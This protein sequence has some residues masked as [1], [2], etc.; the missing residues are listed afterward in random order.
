MLG[1]QENEPRIPKMT[2]S[3]LRRPKARR[4]TLTKG[5]TCNLTETKATPDRGTD[6]M[7]A[8][9]EQEIDLRTL[10]KDEAPLE[11]GEVTLGQDEPTSNTVDP[12]TAWKL[13]MAQFFQQMRCDQK[14]STGETKKG[15]DLIIT[16]E[17]ESRIPKMTL[18][19]LRRPKARRL[20]LTKGKTCNL[21]E[22]KAT[23]DRGTDTMSAAPEQEI[24][25]RTLDKDE[26]PSKRM[27]ENEWTGNY[28]EYC[29][30]FSDIVSNGE[31]LPG[32]DLIMYF[33]AGLPTD[34]GDELT[35]KGKRTFSTWNEAANALRAYMVPFN[36]WRA[37][38]K[39]ALQELQGAEK[40][41]PKRRSHLR[42]YG[43]ANRRHNEAVYGVNR[44]TYST[45]RTTMDGERDTTR[46]FE[47]TGQGHLGRECPLRN[48]VAR[49]RGETCSKCGGMDHYAR[50]CATNRRTTNGNPRVITAMHTE[51]RE[52]ES[53]LNEKA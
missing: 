37:Q 19:E 13:E 24:D 53:R 2:L 30:E 22:T 36:L 28:N 38:R 31:E 7:S 40:P 45:G 12:T 52:G 3:E 6:T 17:N 21:T 1:T 42:E 50:D 43:E 15:A 39:R 27:K 46:C 14:G 35:D 5:K 51:P 18:S 47:C 20:T 33:L 23:P 48:G 44:K 9:P 4:L 8:A 29:N 16:Q 34:I 26:A 41:R 32:H 25:L 10:D 11:A 49:R